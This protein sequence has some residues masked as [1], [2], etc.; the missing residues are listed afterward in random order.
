MWSMKN[1]RTIRW[2][3]EHGIDPSPEVVLLTSRF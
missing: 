3:V 1:P 2:L